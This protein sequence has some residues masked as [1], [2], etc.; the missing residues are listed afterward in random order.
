MVF[1][2]AVIAMTAGA[3]LGMAVGS[4]PGTAELS[5]WDRIFQPITGLLFGVLVL[6]ARF[7]ADTTRALTGRSLRRGT[8]KH[9]GG[10]SGGGGFFGAG[11]GFGDGGG[12]G[13]GDGGGGGGA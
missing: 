10:S 6:C 11:D 3:V 2:L 5:L 12:G 9:A 4:D 8:G 7:L 13:G 1:L